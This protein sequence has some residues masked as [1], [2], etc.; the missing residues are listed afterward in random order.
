MSL[1]PPYSESMH[2]LV[3]LARDP[4]MYLGTGTAVMIL[5]TESALLETFQNCWGFTDVVLKTESC[6]MRAN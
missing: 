3:D 5:A 4:Y 1:D 6:I 2:I